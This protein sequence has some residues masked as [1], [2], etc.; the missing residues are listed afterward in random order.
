MNNATGKIYVTTNYDTF[1]ALTGNRD[2][3]TMHK[4]EIVRSIKKSG[5]FSN[6]I[7]VNER[8]EVIDGQHRLAALKELG[9]PVEYII[10]RGAGAKD[11]PLL[12]TASRNWNTK[13]YI[14]SYADQ[15][16][17]NYKLL[18]ILIQAHP[19][20]RARDIL[21]LC[22][23]PPYFR[24]GASVDTIRKGGFTISRGH[25]DWV[26]RI[27]TLAEPLIEIIHQINTYQDTAQSAILF[28]LTI[29]GVDVGRLESILRKQRDIKTNGDVKSS[30][31]AIGDLYNERRKKGRI[32][33]AE[34]WKTKSHLVK[35]TKIWET[36]AAAWQRVIGC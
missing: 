29:P 27:A 12:N 14:K 18:Q 31:E 9:L 30:V 23:T 6:P 19:G 33:F 7:M 13:N 11:A 3:T 34:A 21:G 28:I 35:L 10:V 26:D 24:C 16:N 4:N 36:Q 25:Y 1:R 20:L 8:M 5:Y 22:A 2:V 15:G 17:G 32:D